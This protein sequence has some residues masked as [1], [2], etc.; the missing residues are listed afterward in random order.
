MLAQIL[1][2][3]IQGLILAAVLVLILG[4]LWLFIRAI[5]KKDKTIKE[6]QARLYEALLISTMIIPILAFAMM[7]ILI[8]LKV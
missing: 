3:Y 5:R 4:A 6:R 1:S 7:G 8:M 2:F